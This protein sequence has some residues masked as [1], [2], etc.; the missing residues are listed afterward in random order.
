MSALTGVSV[1]LWVGRRAGVVTIFLIHQEAN[2]SSLPVS[3]LWY[4]VLNSHRRLISS[5]SEPQLPWIRRKQRMH[6]DHLGT[7]RRASHAC[8]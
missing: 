2:R 7:D 5:P 1:S 3:S 6:V 4:H 8:V